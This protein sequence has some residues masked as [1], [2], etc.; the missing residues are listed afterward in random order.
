LKD[1]IINVTTIQ[2]A[3]NR[4]RVLFN[5]NPLNE[6]VI[7]EFDAQGTTLLFHR[8][9]LEMWVGDSTVE[10]IKRV[11]LRERNFQISEAKRNFEWMQN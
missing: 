9:G 10:K 11:I 6:W 5:K 4:S 2:E 8:S 1:I 7:A 3:R